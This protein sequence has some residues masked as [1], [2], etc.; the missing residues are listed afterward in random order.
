M[1]SLEQLKQ[2]LKDVNYICGK[3]SY[4]GDEILVFKNLYL[5]Y[6]Q[7]NAIICTSCPSNLRHFINV[8]KQHQSIMVTKIEKEIELLETP[9][10]N[11]L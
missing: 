5:K 7:K 2:D 4:R 6:V 11:E 1:V 10:N 3:T 8:F 9:N